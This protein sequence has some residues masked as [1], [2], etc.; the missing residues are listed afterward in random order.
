LDTSA[1]LTLIEDED[2]GARVEQVIREENCLIP[3]VALLETTYITRQERGEGE[4]EHR[5]ALIKQLPV[6][7]L[8]DMDEPTLLTAA[9]IKA[10]HHLSLAD[11]II[12]AYAMRNKAVLIHKNPEFEVLSGIVWLESLPYK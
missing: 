5:Y 9:K 4:A 1:L 11:A 8:W 3:W 6:T 10:N 12:V 7:I 2:G